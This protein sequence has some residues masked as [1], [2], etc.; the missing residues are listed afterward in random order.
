MNRS[1]PSLVGGA[2]QAGSQSG[3][4]CVPHPY[5]LP[6]H[7]LPWYDEWVGGTWCHTSQS[8][9]GPPPWS[10][11]GRLCYWPAGV[12]W[13]R[14]LHGSSQWCCRFEGLCL[15]SLLVSESPTE[16]FQQH[17]LG[18]LRCLQHLLQVGGWRGTSAPTTSP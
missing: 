1:L 18:W 5:C 9:A 15:L 7:W 8:E 13:G 2:V 3:V 17:C 16:P 6:S 11:E 12:P 14:A 4:V 10:V